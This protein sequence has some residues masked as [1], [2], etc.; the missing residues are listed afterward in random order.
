MHHG[1][2]DRSEHSETITL[3]VLG[4]TEKPKSVFLKDINPDDGVLRVFIAFDEHDCSHEF[5]LKSC[6]DCGNPIFYRN[7]Q[8]ADEFTIRKP[9]R[10]II[11]GLNLSKYK[12]TQL[13]LPQ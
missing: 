13:L 3:E 2:F 12:L 9:V 6:D 11:R 5:M 8:D 10:Y 7:R 4:G 1:T